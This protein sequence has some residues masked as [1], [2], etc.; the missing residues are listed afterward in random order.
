MYT[1]Y[2]SEHDVKYKLHPRVQLCSFSHSRTIAHAHAQIPV[3]EAPGQ[4]KIDVVQ[5]ALSLTIHSR[6]TEGNNG[7]A[8]NCHYEKKNPYKA[9]YMQIEHDTTA[10]E[11]CPSY[12]IPWFSCGTSLFIRLIHRDE[13]KDK[14]YK[15]TKSHKP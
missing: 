1:V 8:S 5:H 6:M 14:A 13:A 2:M 7:K 4:E 3:L 12:P 9:C 11:T 15:N 10:Q